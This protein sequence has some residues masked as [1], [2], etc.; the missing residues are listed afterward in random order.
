M[1]GQLL[2][3]SRHLGVNM[4]VLKSAYGVIFDLF[5]RGRPR[6]RTFKD[7]AFSF[8][9]PPRNETLPSVDL[10]YAHLHW[11]YAPDAQALLEVLGLLL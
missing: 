4:T 2:T 3:Q 8:L 1:T 7:G 10:G 11:H 9:A 6:S 5:T